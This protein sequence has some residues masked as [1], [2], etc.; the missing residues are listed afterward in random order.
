VDLR[1]YQHMVLLDWRQLRST[2]EQPWDKLCDAL[3][4]AGVYSV[5]EALSKL[6]LRPLHEALRHAVSAHTVATFVKISRELAKAKDVREV[7]PKIE[8]ADKKAEA[9]GKTALPVDGSAAGV[10]A[11]ETERAVLDSRLQ[12]FVE[13]SQHFFDRATEIMPAEDKEAMF[14]AAKKTEVPAGVS[15][16]AAVKHDEPTDP[17]QSYKEKVEEMAEAAVQ[18]LP[19]ERNFST[20]WPE[21][22]R[23]VLPHDDAKT[24]PERT[25]AAVLGW[26]V[27]GSMPWKHEALFDKLQMRAAIAE[28]FSS[29]GL[30][31]EDMW[32]AAAR[33]RVL[34]TQSCETVAKAG[35]TLVGCMH[36][37]AFWADGDVQWLTGV[38]KSA[39]ATYFNK[40]GFEEMISWLQLPAMIEI[41]R[42]GASAGKAIAELEAGV[43]EDCRVAAKS[44]YK[45]D[46]Y[47]SAWKPKGVKVSKVSEVSEEDVKRDLVASQ[48]VGNS[49]VE[50]SAAS[51]TELPEVVELP[52]DAGKK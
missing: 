52:V 43:V 32:R 12:E 3:N 46:T 36:T 11:P 28:I 30:E 14:S 39:G 4:G 45:L 7:T 6:R 35:E 21:A 40:E 24:H 16:S 13:K 23:S 50:G 15:T 8:V 38:N 37:E 9:R 49:T 34:L 31:G 25:W 1:G 2:E 10:V 47:L 27:L 17:R 33:V 48:A 29:M 26:I 41:A 18:L 22:G 42:R 5:N 51:A 20:S 44:G 19:L